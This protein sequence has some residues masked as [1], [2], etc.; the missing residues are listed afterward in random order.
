MVGICIHYPYHSDLRT[1][2]AKAGWLAAFHGSAWT[3][4][5]SDQ[6]LDPEQRLANRA[7]ERQLEFD[8]YGV[9]SVKSKIDCA[10]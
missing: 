9:R 10:K 6:V 4:R 2:Q 1:G 7:L 5:G 8:S 3:W